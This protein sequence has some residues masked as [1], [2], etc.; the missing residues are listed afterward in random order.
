MKFKY[1]EHGTCRGDV[2]LDGDAVRVSMRGG[3]NAA[4]D[5]FS[6]AEVMPLYKAFSICRREAR[7]RET[8]LPDGRVYEEY[9][10]AR[11]GRKSVTIWAIVSGE[12]TLDLAI[13]DETGELRAVFHTAK[14]G[15]AVLAQEGWEGITPVALW[16]DGLLPQAVPV[17][18][19][20]TEFVAMRDG[21]R[22]ATEIWLPAS[23]GP[24]YPAVLMRTPYGRLADGKR[25]T[26]LAERG[27]ALIAQDVRGRDDSEG[28]FLPS[29][30]EAPDGS[31]TLDWLAS[32]SWCDG[33]VGMIGGS[34]LGSVQWQAAST[35]HPALK[36]IVSQVTAGGPFVD[37]PR[38]GGAFCAG[39]LPWI[40]MMSEK[41]AAKGKMSREDWPELLASRPLCAI[42]EKALGTAPAFWDEYMKHPDYDEFWRRCDWASRAGNIDV[43]ALMISGWYDDDGMGTLQAWEMNAS[44]GRKNQRL[45]L[46]PWRHSYN[47]SRYIH[48]VRFGPDA[49]RYDL[50]ILELRWFE[51]FLKG[52][53]NGVES[54]VAQYYSVGENAWKESPSWPPVDSRPVSVYL[55][56]G[57]RANGSS[58]DGALSSVPPESEPCDE[59]FY[60]PDDPAPQLIDMAENEMA[61]PGNYRDAESR[62]DI[63]VYTSAPLEEPLEIAG[64]VTAVLYASSDAPDTD[65]LVRLTDV[66]PDGNSIRLADRMI[67]ARYRDSW[68]EPK[69]LAPGEIVRYDL[70]LPH[71]ANVFLKGH[72]IRVHVT[73]S[74][75]NLI[76]PNPNTGG[77]I[78]T[79]TR[80]QVARQ[81]V[82]HNKGAESRVLLPVRGNSGLPL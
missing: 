44:R 74:A 56:G 36:A 43:P 70:R 35:G 61:V 2:E 1:Y 65:W 9:R 3:A 79:E 29:A 53:D 7:P 31:D 81:R 30:N 6:F 73:S 45:I 72:R 51:R 37:M 14:S 59:Y 78:F 23:G 34:Y 54:P 47:T 71:V 10:N 50:D 46:G 67:Q 15:T 27:Y 52:A 22:L 42:P 12:P 82:F 4:E 69:L 41:S 8:L 24:K 75:A 68:S 66:D 63:L 49:L 28:E 21:T 80:A 64:N 76:F 58:G 5:A 40:F 38:P 32:Q 11:D 48:G 18:R 77:D 17:R 55:R 60:D 20:G 13:D 19:R 33:S 16:N 62:A 25:M 57:G 26:Y 39:L